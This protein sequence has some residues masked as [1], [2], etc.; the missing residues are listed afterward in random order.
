VMA[1]KAVSLTG[2]VAA[3]S[4]GNFLSPPILERHRP[5]SILV[6]SSVSATGSKF[7]A[8]LTKSPTPISEPQVGDPPAFMLLNVQVY[9]TNVFSTPLAMTTYV[10][11]PVRLA[12]SFYNAATSEATV[13]VTYLYEV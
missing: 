9:G 6:W 8:F 12:F 1:V 11:P 5:V 7:S 2:T 4:T 10:D 3:G 13:V